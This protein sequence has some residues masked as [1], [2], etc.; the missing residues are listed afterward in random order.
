MSNSLSKSDNID[1][2]ASS[3]VTIQAICDWLDTPPN[4]A[5]YELTLLKTNLDVI[6]A[7]QITPQQRTL[8]LNRLYSR[9][10]SAVSALTPLL[11]GV[12]FPIH[13]KTRH[14]IRGLQDLLITLS[15]EALS[16]LDKTT[17][18]AIHP[19]LPPPDLLLW[20]SLS[21]LSQHLLTSNLAASPAGKGVWHKLH[22]TFDR[23][24][25][26]G[27]SENKPEGTNSSLKT[28]YYS[29]I[30]LG[31]AQPASFSSSEISFIASYLDFFADRIDVLAES[32]PNPL[33]SFWI[34]PE[35]DEP[36]IAYSR[37]KPPP[38]TQVH[39]FSCGRLS[40]L[41]AEQLAALECGHSPK[42]IGLPDFSGTPA[43]HGVIRRLVTYWGRPGKRRFPR[44]RQNHRAALCAGLGSLCQ[45]L[46]NRETSTT[47]LSSWMITN[48]SPDGYA[49]M[50]VSGKTGTISVGNVI[51]IQTDSG[52][53]WQ[54]GIVRWAISENQEHLELG[55]Q[56][57]ATHATPALL[58]LSSPSNPRA[59]LPVLILPQIPDLRPNELLIAPSGTLDHH[60][61]SFVLIVEKDNLAVREVRS[62]LLD[63]QNGLIEVF[64]IAPV[65]DSA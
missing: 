58:A 56:I 61:K 7:A 51:A 52:K 17:G 63:E 60:P 62:T 49:L 3:A 21:A 9:S 14:L 30:L 50:H 25:H 41:L 13:R 15:E 46:Q 8:L 22:Q 59:S 20:R 32:K 48:E 65:T 1:S 55:L 45:L 11:I 27:L 40:A 6:R 35:R 5:S 18:Q 10:I 29:A 64:S 39:F 38:E 57:L 34:D 43:G 26:L 36:A 44:R 4:D 28:I 12:S 24:R 31:C 2:A 33:N 53:N 23:A 47:E 16:T 37:K 54:I 42:Q 19:E